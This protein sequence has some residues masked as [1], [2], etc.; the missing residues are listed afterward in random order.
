MPFS[1]GQ[2]ATRHWKGVI[3][4]VLGLCLGGIYAATSMPSSVFPQTNFPRVSIMIDNGEM[5]ADEMLA[6][7]TK[8]I[9]EAMKDIPGVVRIRSN[10]G[11]GSAVVDV[12]FNWQV[13]MDQSEL[14]VRARLSQV[15]SSL[16]AAGEAR[17]CWRAFSGCPSTGVSLT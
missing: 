12:F 3:F 16:P 13:D 7:I 5:P 15:R 9:E 2:F 4:I 14:H 10:T 17:G 11:R 8:P 6:T 1:L